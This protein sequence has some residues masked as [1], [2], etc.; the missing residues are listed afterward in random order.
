MFCKEVLS[1]IFPILKNNN[2]AISHMNSSMRFLTVNEVW[3]FPFCINNSRTLMQ[4]L[5]LSSSKS[6]TN[7]ILPYRDSHLCELFH[8]LHNKAS[9]ISSRTVIIGNP[10]T[11]FKAKISKNAHGLGTNVLNCSDLRLSFSFMW[12]WAWELRKWHISSFFLR[13]LEIWIQTI[14]I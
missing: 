14:Y 7:W 3:L 12:K 6:F 5:L 13:G 2:E 4:R 9:S 8:L 11:F 10:D 1:L